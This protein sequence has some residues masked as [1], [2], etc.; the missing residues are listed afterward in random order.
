M[1]GTVVRVRGL[2]QYRHPKTGILYTY[3][4]ATGKRILAEPGTPEF[5]AAVAALDADAKADEQERLKPNTLGGLIKSYKTTDAWSDLAPRTRRDYEKVFA[6]LAPLYPAPVIAFTAPRLVA[7]RDEWRKQRG[8]RF[9][10]Y[11]RTVM[12]LLMGRAV[13]LGLATENTARAVRQVKRDRN[14]APLNRPWSAAEQHAV[15]ERTGSTRYRHLR[16]PLAIGL[17][18]GMR[19]ADMITLPRHAIR[20]GR[21]AIETRKRKV[22]IDLTILP[23]LAAAIA[24][25]PLANATTLCVNSRGLPWTQDGFRASFFRMVRELHAEGAVHTGLT[26]HGL[27]HTVASLLAERGVAL[28][29]IAAVLGQKSS[30]V[31]EIYTDRADRTRRAT[32][33]I[34]KLMP[35]TRRKR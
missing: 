15:W 33:A 2:K 23:D 8:R 30:K 3:H 19:Q 1:A 16:L 25:A 9:V 12:I 29:D 6:F 18:T 27:R 21:L 17:Y 24:D 34:A 26:Y 14:A 13:E 4:R 10:N 11:C 35:R 20:D 31:A 32:A 5:L 7:L 28:E 22:W